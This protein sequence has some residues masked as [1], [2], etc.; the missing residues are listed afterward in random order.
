MGKKEEFIYD[1]K[2]YEGVSYMKMQPLKIREDHQ[3]GSYIIAPKRVK[4]DI[5]F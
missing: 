3:R 1:N 5:L 2:N 4:L